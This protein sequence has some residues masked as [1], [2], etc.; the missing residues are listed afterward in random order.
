MYTEND[1]YAKHWRVPFNKTKNVTSSKFILSAIPSPS[2]QSSF[3][4]YDL[5]SSDEE[6]L[7]PTNVARTT[8]GKSYGAVHLLTAASLYM[9]SMPEVP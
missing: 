7:T 6:Y 2:S 4:P 5:S 1:Y 9:D 3:D 8:P